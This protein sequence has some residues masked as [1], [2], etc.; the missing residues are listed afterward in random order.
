MPSVTSKI[1]DVYVFRRAGVSAEVLQ[2]FRSPD[3]R[4]GAT[5][6]SVHGTIEAGE[7]AWQAAR[8][9]LMEETGLSP[10]RAW[11]LESVNTFYSARD[12]AVHLCPGFAIEVPADAEVRLNHEHTEFRWL[13]EGAAETEFLWPGQRNAIREIR[14]VILGRTPAEALL[15]IEFPKVVSGDGKPRP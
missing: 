4:L 13:T 1:V 10:M 9:E 14:E 15:R 2:L 7:H 8:R 5:W 12:D 11:Q 3:S 6:Q